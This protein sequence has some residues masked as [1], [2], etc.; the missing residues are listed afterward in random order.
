MEFWRLTNKPPKQWRSLAMTFW[1]RKNQHIRGQDFPT[2][3]PQ[4]AIDEVFF[5]CLKFSN[6]PACMWKTVLSLDLDPIWNV[7][8]LGK[9]PI[10]QTQIPSKSRKLGTSDPRMGR[11]FVWLKLTWK[12]DLTQLTTDPKHQCTKCRLLSPWRCVCLDDN[13]ATPWL[14]HGSS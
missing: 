9:F 10:F 7:T 11:T 13:E 4:N 14:A 6:M 5:V 3:K 1:Q 8:F 12:D 2:T